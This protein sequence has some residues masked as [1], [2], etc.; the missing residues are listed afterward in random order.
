MGMKLSAEPLKDKAQTGQKMYSLVR[1][2]ADDLDL[3]LVKLN[4][5]LVA[6]SNVPFESLFDI[7]K[8]IPF[9]RDGKPVEL[10]ARPYHA[11]KM[12]LQGR[13]LDCK[14]KAVI[15]ASWIHKN[16]G[17]GFY[18]FVATSNRADKKITHTFP[19]IAVNRKW[20]PVDAT[21][22]ENKPFQKS[23]LTKKVVLNA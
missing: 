1:N 2:Y 23:G 8:N 14:K 9:Q 21:Y 4:G 17:P 12:A 22:R 16:Y 15:I 10:L 20:Y 3:V 6:L 19:E 7:V 18:R 11:F 13:G 5:K